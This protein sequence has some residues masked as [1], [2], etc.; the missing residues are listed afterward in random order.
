MYQ[1]NYTFVGIGSSMFNSFF[2]T[3]VC[4]SITFSIFS[5]SSF[6]VL[7]ESVSARNSYNKYLTSN[8]KVSYNVI[9]FPFRHNLHIILFLFLCQIINYFQLIVQTNSHILPFLLLKYLTS[10][11]RENLNPILKIFH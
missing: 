2:I 10:K 6:D 4:F 11:I 9:A 7:L 3:G 1:L 5:I 8:I